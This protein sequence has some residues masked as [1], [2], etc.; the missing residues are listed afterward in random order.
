MMTRPLHV[1]VLAVLAALLAACAISAAPTRTSAPTATRQPSATPKPSPTAAPTATPK[2][3][4]TP[5]APTVAVPADFGREHAQALAQV[6]AAQ[7]A[8]RV[9]QIADSASALARLATQSVH[10][11]VSAGARPAPSSRLLCL[12][13]YVAIVH[14][15]S[16]LDE[17]SAARLRA[18]VQGKDWTGGVFYSGD[19]AVM[20]RVLGM[21]D[22][23]AYARALPTWQ[24]VVDRVAGDRTAFAFVPWNEVDARV[25]TLSIDGR[26]IAAN[27][28]Q[29]YAIGDA[30][31][32]SATS[33]APETI[34]AAL[35]STLACP[36]REPV[37]FLAAGD[38][39]MGWFVDE[40]YVK[41]QGPEYLFKRIADLTRSADIAFANFENPM[42]TRGVMENKGLM[43]RASPEAVKGLVYGGLDVVNLA[44]NHF[45]DYGAQAML[46]TFDILK[47]NGIGYVG[48]G[49]NRSEARAPWLTTV[50]GVKIAVLAYNEIEPGFFS[51]TDARPG[52]AWIE[53]ENVY[54]EIKRARTQADFVIV[55]FHWGIEYTVHPNSRQQELARRAAE[56]G[57]GLVI[58]HHPHVVQGID[59]LGKVYVNY[60]IGDFVY[61]QPTRPATGEG[62]ILR[63][64]IDGA[65]LRQVQM[66]PIYVDRA[67]PYVI[68]PVEAKPM[69]A[70]IFDA[71]RLYDGFPQPSTSTA[72]PAAPDAT[73]PQASVAALRGA[74]TFVELNGEQA[75]IVMPGS[76]V[77]LI[78]LTSDGVLNDAPRWSPDGKRIAYSSARDGSVD[79]FVAAADGSGAVNLTRNAAWDDYPAW[80]PDGSKIAFTSNRDGPFNLYVMNA[81]GS[82]VRRLT[83][84]NDWDT[85]PAWSPD[86]TRIAFASDRG[87]TFQI[88]TMAADGS[89]VRRISNG[90]RLDAFPAWSPDGKSIAYQSYV[91]QSLLQ[92][93]DSIQ[94]RDYEIMVAP[95]TGGA[96]RQ[97]TNNVFADIQP[98]WSAD[99]KQIA[100]A[101]D[102][103][104][105]FRIYVMDVGSGAV[106]AVNVGAGAYVAPAWA[107]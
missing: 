89:D 17:L 30:W 56:A 23:G 74:L 91:D 99:G 1:L 98:A 95:A 21:D 82:G 25:K 58:G 39:L 66:I 49:R 57:A 8:L 42:S 69:M 86:G 9:E 44:N 2:P 80:S 45:G 81:D 54:A 85:M 73:L 13:P 92:G 63:A 59:F 71:T 90:A 100:F 67:Q 12:T 38:M 43:F 14:Y 36:A 83:R 60:S 94:D 97:L 3:S 55:S 70:R 35:A 24:A 51:A 96:A 40:L 53:P 11:A 77:P 33:T 32:L 104:G 106:S 26:S 103:D 87:D 68:S 10:W 15:T 64:V 48:A 65:A 84:G 37:T 105:R 28:V 78:R 52:T 61:S 72:A 76:G 29:G 41:K 34:G 79:I 47:Q 75:N 5:K 62:I 102:R 31:W 18:I 27:G 88:Y 107:P 6:Q 20:R 101:S 4:P 93:D 46:D 50:K 7:P 22:L 19:A 16:P